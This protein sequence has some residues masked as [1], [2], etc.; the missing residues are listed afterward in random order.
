MVKVHPLFDV[1]LFKLTGGMKF[2]LK[3]HAFKHVD[4]TIVCSCSIASN[5]HQIASFN[6]ELNNS[7][8][9][10]CGLN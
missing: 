4:S 10:K 7:I 1:S 2:C 5:V 8:N 3:F 6:F 9:L